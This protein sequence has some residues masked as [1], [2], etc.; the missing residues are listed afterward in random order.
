MGMGLGRIDSRTARQ[1]KALDGLPSVRCKNRQVRATARM[2]A[3]DDTCMSTS[4]R[5]SR[6]NATRWLKVPS[7]AGWVGDDAE[8]ASAGVPSSCCL[9]SAIRFDDDALGVSEPDRARF[10]DFLLCFE[11]RREV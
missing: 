5:I 4:A 1:M 9:V 11:G 6:G 10:L 8:P 2:S 3:G 7:E